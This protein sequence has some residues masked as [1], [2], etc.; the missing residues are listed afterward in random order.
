M[1]LGYLVVA[2]L[3]AFAVWSGHSLAT[4]ERAAVAIGVA[5]LGALAAWGRWRGRA[6]D[7]WVAD[8]AAFAVATVRVRWR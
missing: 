3:A 4:P 7:G 1:R 6:L 8:I 5:A 2:L